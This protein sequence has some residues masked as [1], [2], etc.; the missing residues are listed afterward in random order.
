MFHTPEF[1]T[2]HELLTAVGFVR[3]PK[4]T[5]RGYEIRR[6]IPYL[7][8]GVMKYPGPRFARIHAIVTHGYIN[9]HVDEQMPGKK[10][11]AHGSHPWV[12]QKIREIKAL[13][14]PLYDV[15]ELDYLRE[16]ISQ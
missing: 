1:K 15:P 16:L 2:A 3:C 8:N 12:Q 9:I 10:H 7:H 5:D 4:S 11:I 6:D 14:R 13:D